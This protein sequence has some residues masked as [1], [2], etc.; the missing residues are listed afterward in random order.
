MEGV[1]VFWAALK[2]RE[3]IWRCIEIKGSQTLADF[4]RIMRRAFNHDPGN[5]LSDFYPGLV[6]DITGYGIPRVIT[7]LR[8]GPTII[9][10]SID[11]I[12]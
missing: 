11:N 5:H 3:E 9:K 6:G 7:T 1:Y 12:Q 4:D 2:Y 10:Y 8:G